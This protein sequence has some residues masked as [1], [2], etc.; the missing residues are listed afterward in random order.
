MA[1]FRSIRCSNYSSICVK[2][3]YWRIIVP[4]ALIFGAIIEVI[5]PYLK[6]SED[7]YDFYANATGVIIGLII[8]LAV[9]V[10]YVRRLQ[11]IS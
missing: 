3:A 11:E 9:N 8:G 1:S 6:R 4:F 10:F 7:I 5:Q 2:V